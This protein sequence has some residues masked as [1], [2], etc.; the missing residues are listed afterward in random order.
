MRKLTLTVIITAMFIVGTF[1]AEVSDE[2]E[3]Y[4]LDLSK[5]LKDIV[6]GISSGS[7][8]A[9]RR[10]ESGELALCLPQ[11]VPQLSLN[12]VV[13]KHDPY[14]AYRISFSARVE[15]PDSLEDNPVLKN[16]VLGRGMKKSTPA[17]SFG[18]T[19]SKD[20][21]LP[22]H[23]KNFEL[24][25][26]T[27]DEARILNKVWTIYSDT[28]FIPENAESLILRFSTAESQDM[29]FVKN[30]KI[31]EVNTSR[32]INPNWD[33]SAG[34]LNF[35][36]LTNRAP[37]K[38]GEDGKFRLMVAGGHVGLRRVPVKPGEKIRISTKGR[39]G[40]GTSYLGYD[41]FGSSLK[42][43]K[44]GRWILVWNG[45]YETTVPEGAAYISWLIANSDAEFVK[46]ERI[47]EFTQDGKAR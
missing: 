4:R 20:E 10:D 42:K 41:Y 17:W 43:V 30:L 26:Y 21:Q 9:I 40:T 45:S 33:F 16:L 14:K 8:V 15:G 35:T 19:Y 3:V 38:K 11:K 47:D 32:I 22:A 12:P 2:K 44:E 25:G 28:I 46:I 31:T 6:K 36:G 37:I 23:Q 18:C 1:A 34:E 27:A 5:E 24:F 13:F 39:A 29:L 7:G